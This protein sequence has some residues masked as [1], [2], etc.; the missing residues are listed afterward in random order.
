[1]CERK[2]SEW[3]DIG[4][5]PLID[6]LYY[7]LR[8]KPCGSVVYIAAGFAHHCPKCEPEEFEKL[9]KIVL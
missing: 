4:K 6:D 8:H 3:E 7:T 5:G 1:M 2:E 9:R